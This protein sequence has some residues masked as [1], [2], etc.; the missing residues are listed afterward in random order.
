MCSRTVACLTW[1]FYLSP[2][3]QYAFYI[4]YLSCVIHSTGILGSRECFKLMSPK[5]FGGSIVAS[6]G[7]YSRCPRPAPVMFG[8]LPRSCPG[9]TKL[10]IAQYLQNTITNA[11]RKR[12]SRP[13]RLKFC[14]CGVD[15]YIAKYADQSPKIRT[16]SRIDNNQT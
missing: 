8:G 3:Q 7:R 14:L 10:I 9:L 16:P 15:R 12:L 2:S 1:L 5:L 6:G 4:C 13:T 11:I